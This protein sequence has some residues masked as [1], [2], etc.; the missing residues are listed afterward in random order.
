MSKKIVIIESPGKIEKISSILRGIG[1]NYSVIASRGHIRDLDKSSLSIDIN[2]NFKPLYIISH[3]KKNIVK[4]LRDLIN[5][6][7][8]NVIIAT[9]NDREGEGIAMSLVDILKINDYNRIVFTEITQKAITNALKK[10]MKININLAHAQEARRILDRLMGYI[11]SPVLWKYLNK[12]AKSAGRVQSVVN[13]III[14]KENE[15]KNAIENTSLYCKIIGI[16]NDMTCKLEVKAINTIEKANTFLMLLTNK[17]VFK[18]DNIEN[19]TSIRKPSPPFITSTLQQDAS[20]KL[21]YN[22]KKTMEIAQKLYEMGLITYMRTDSPNISEDIS[23]ECLQYIQKNHGKQ[24]S[25]PRNYK[26]TN[27]SSQE[28]HECIRPTHIESDISM[29][30]GEQLKLYNLIWKRTVASQMSNANINIMV[31]CIDALNKK[32]SLLVF[33]KQY[34]FKA[35]N[36]TILFD[37]YMVLYD[38][39]DNNDNNDNSDKK[40]NVSCPYKKDDVLTMDKIKITEEYTAL[41]LRYTEAGLIRYLETNGIGRP[42]TF[43]SIITKVIERNYIEIKNIEGI[44]KKA[45]WLELSKT[46]KLKEG[47]KIIQI[48]SEKNKLVSTPIG[49]MINDFLMKHFINIINIEFTAQ[50]EENLD[51]IAMG[52][53]NYSTII[54]NFYNMFNPTVEKLLKDKQISNDILLGTKNDIL[55]YKGEGKFGPYVKVM[56]NDKWKY[57][58]T[59]DIKNIDIETALMLLKYP[60]ILGNIGKNTVTLNNGPYGL[61]IKNGNTNIPIKDD[62]KEDDI[63]IDYVIKNSNRMFHVKDKVISIRNGDYGHYLQITSE[64]N[65]NKQNISIPQKYNTENMTIDDVM[66]II[67]NKNS[68]TKK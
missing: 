47:S 60:K 27:S 28:A 13:R 11:I 32:E 56:E 5:N 53:A 50:L 25:E 43:A 18:I 42:S 40:E 7:N 16:F 26:S 35:M 46:F 20:T 38:N 55:I 33:D 57:A 63:D 48:G 41:P 59:K 64:K 24:Y 1:G 36:E 65:K 17:T 23:K 12:E 31:I 22:P 30:K 51:L 29:L 21:K 67:S 54:R 6:N 8:N 61:Y 19:K 68:Y 10:Q 2:D 15:I 4:E 66:Q 9:D 58:S 49:M 52:K 37:G 44:E 45:K 39:N 14:D 62:I 34:Y 3:D